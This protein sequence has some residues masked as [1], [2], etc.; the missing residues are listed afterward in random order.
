MIKLRTKATV[1][2]ASAILALG[3]ILTFSIITAAPGEAASRVDAQCPNQVYVG[4]IHSD[5]GN[6]LDSY[7]VSGQ[8]NP[9]GYVHTW[10]H[11]SGSDNQLWC[12]EKASQH[13]GGYFIHVLNPSGKCLD[14]GP[15]TQ[16]TK[17]WVWGCNGTNDQRWCWTGNGYLIRYNQ[18]LGLKDKGAYNIVILTEEEASKWYTTGP[19][20]PY[21]C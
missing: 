20:F 21:N 7:G 9:P 16:A 15:N 18:D 4:T 6:Y 19:T 8:N 2:C 10:P 13:L 14:G 17:V 3:S 11:T 5:I 1:A 12:V